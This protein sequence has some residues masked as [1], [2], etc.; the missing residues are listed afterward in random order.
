MFKL[1]FKMLSILFYKCEHNLD[2]SNFVYVGYHYYSMLLF[3]LYS[4]LLSFY[5]NHGTDKC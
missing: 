3:T 4:Y 2:T 5:F 1:Y